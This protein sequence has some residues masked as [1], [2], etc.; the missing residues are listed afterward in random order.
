[1]AADLNSDTAVVQPV[2]DPVA[3]HVDAA[4]FAD[5]AL[6]LCQEPVPRGAVSIGD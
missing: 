5:L 6:V 1:M 3:Q 4:A 2:L